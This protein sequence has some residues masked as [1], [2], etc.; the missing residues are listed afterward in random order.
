MPKRPNRS[1][2]RDADD[3]LSEVI[4][5]ILILALIAIFLSIWMTYVVPAEGRQQEIEHMNYV[6]DWFTQYKVTA[7]SLWINHGDDKSLT[8]MTFS[9][10][11]V[12][13]SQ[14]GA[15][16]AGGL[17]MPV[18]NPIG[19][20]GGIAV[21]N[22]SEFIVIGGE[23]Y[24]LSILEFE[25]TNNYW[26]PQSYYYQMGGVFLRQPAGT[27]A[28]VAPL[29]HFSQ[30]HTEIV[31]VQ[32]TSRRASG[33]SGQGPV[34]VDTELNRADKILTEGTMPIIFELRDA[35]AAKGWANILKERRE[36]AD[37]TTSNVSIDLP[38]NDK[39]ITITRPDNKNDVS[40]HIVEL[41]VSVQSIASGVE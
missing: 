31:I 27:V 4:G 35:N 12:L 16:Q 11:L 37:L 1:K 22:K 40:Y 34:R 15:T 33:M 17:F 36:L 20:T 24:P 2:R 19:S 38:P 21:T 29:I 26:I 32:I 30:D 6:R 5:F 13:G 25:T 14:G 41:V 7:D 8:G 28:R 10:S 3:A 39:V 18:M 23:R 9:N